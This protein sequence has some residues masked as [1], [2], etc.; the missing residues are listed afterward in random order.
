MEGLPVFVGRNRE[1]ALEAMVKECR[2]N[3]DQSTRRH[4]FN[5]FPRMGSSRLTSAHTSA[6]FLMI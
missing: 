5:P 3:I 2:S 6:D 4:S 1:K